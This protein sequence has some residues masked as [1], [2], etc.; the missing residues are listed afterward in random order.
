MDSHVDDLNNCCDS[1]HLEN[2]RYMGFLLETRVKE[3]EELN[4]CLIECSSM[5][6]GVTSS[7][8]LS[9]SLNLMAFQITLLTLLSGGWQKML[10]EL[11]LNFS[12]F[13]LAMKNSFPLSKK[14]GM[15]SVLEVQC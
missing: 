3:K 13:W 11:R 4:A 8:N 2:L 14:H 10:G 12:T 1:V 6:S 5:I 7:M 9:R 15:E